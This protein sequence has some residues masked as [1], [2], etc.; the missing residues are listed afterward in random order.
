MD[1]LIEVQHNFIIVSFSQCSTDV[2]VSE[3]ILHEISSLCLL[4]NMKNIITDA[5]VI[6]YLI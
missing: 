1:I 2:F 3:E 6:K 5:S 4:I